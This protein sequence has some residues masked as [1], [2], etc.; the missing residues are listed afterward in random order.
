MKERYPWETQMLLGHPLV[1][2]HLYHEGKLTM[3]KSMLANF[4][5]TPSAH[6]EMLETLFLHKSWYPSSFFW[7]FFFLSQAN[8]AA[9]LN[10]Y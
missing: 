3:Q 5:T 9:I 8:S 10:K 1:Y 2:Y 7:G 6:K 4:L